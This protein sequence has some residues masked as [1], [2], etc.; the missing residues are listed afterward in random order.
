MS[1]VLTE[2]YAVVANFNNPSYYK[3]Y[4]WTVIKT[5]DLLKSAK[6][7]NTRM[8]KHPF[9]VDSKIFTYKLAGEYQ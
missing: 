1:K 4:T 8:K 5:Y 6:A 7:Y 9:I 3:S 2:V